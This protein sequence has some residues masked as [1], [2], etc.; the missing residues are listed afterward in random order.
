MYCTLCW[1]SSFMT[2][3]SRLL[4]PFSLHR[5]SLCW[6]QLVAMWFETSCHYNW[7][8]F[9][10]STSWSLIRIKIA[11][12]ISCQSKSFIQQVCHWQP[13]DWLLLICPQRC[14]VFHAPH[15]VHVEVSI[16]KHARV[17]Y[18]EVTLASRHPSHGRR[19]AIWIFNGATCW[20]L[21]WCVYSAGGTGRLRQLLCW[22]RGRTWTL[23]LLHGSRTVQML[24]LC[25]KICVSPA[26]S[27]Q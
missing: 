24:L 1:I 22:S 20:E 27:K 25:E 19:N 6:Q 13:F 23:S 10:L 16:C 5:Q 3:F 17:L 14:S 21:G 26:L 18:Q 4:L 11:G 2:S 8:V 9:I 12:G 7:C 15:L